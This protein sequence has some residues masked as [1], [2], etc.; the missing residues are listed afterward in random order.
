MES[1]EDE[2]VKILNDICKWNTE[3]DHEE[4]NSYIHRLLE[5]VDNK[6]AFYFVHDRYESYLEKIY[7]ALGYYQ[8][9]LFNIQIEGQTIEHMTKHC[10]KI[11]HIDFLDIIAKTVFSS[12]FICGKKTNKRCH[13]ILGAY[14]CGKAC[15][16]LDWK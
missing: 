1:E 10:T 11:H 2:I 6:L 8:Y 5:S 15:Q 3:N 12:C 16:K 7:D 13:C 9:G 14:Y 4:L